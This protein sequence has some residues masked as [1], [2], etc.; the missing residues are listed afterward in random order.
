MNKW[1]KECEWI[2]LHIHEMIPI[3]LEEKQQSLESVGQMEGLAANEAGRKSSVYSFDFHTQ[4]VFMGC[5]LITFTG[6][7]K[8]SLDAIWQD[9]ATKNN[10]KSVLKEKNTFLIACSFFRC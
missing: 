9:R 8:H 6:P 3:F 2:T 4:A 5:F 7:W 1:L 10:E